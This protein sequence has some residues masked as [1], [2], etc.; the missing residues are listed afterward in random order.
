[1][2]HCTLIATTGNLQGQQYVVCQD[3]STCYMI[4]KGQL[5]NSIHFLLHKMLIANNMSHLPHQHKRLTCRDTICNYQMSCL[6]N[7]LIFLHCLERVARR[8][9]KRNRIPSIATPVGGLS[10]EGVGYNGRGLESLSLSHLWWDMSYTSWVSDSSHNIMIL[11]KT[12]LL[13][14][15]W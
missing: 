6:Q 2:C 4:W 7:L 14:I 10:P 8:R 13:N 1:M 5:S 11:I 12:S 9:K 3:R 15:T